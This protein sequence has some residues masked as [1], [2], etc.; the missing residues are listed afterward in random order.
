M[1]LRRRWDKCL[2]LD[3]MH[4]AA[5]SNTSAVCVRERPLRFFKVIDK[6]ADCFRGPSQWHE[7]CCQT[8]TSLVFH[9]SSCSINKCYTT[10]MREVKWALAE[11]PAAATRHSFIFNVSAVAVLIYPSCYLRVT[12][13]I[14]SS[15]STPTPARRR[16]HS[17][18][19]LKSHLKV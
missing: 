11:A 1:L 4:R 6:P 19:V 2:H 3:H 17:W 7:R 9:W 14:T 12:C 10:L 16:S 5:H 13:P 15:H 18:K 8:G